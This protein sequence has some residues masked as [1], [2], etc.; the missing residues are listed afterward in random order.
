MAWY[1]FQCRPFRKLH[2]DPVD[3]GAPIVCRYLVE[4][5]DA[6]LDLTLSGQLSILSC[7]ETRRRDLWWTTLEVE[8][9]GRLVGGSSIKPKLELS[10]VL[11]RWHGR[12]FDAGNFTR[13]MINLSTVMIP[14][15]EHF[16]SKVAM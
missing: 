6:M 13:S 16:S 12:C 2:D 4:G 5:R 7:T 11:V 8:R 14:S 1:V 10:R 9:R 15:C 3:N